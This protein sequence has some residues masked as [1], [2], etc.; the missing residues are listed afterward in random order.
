MQL[1][2]QTGTLN[3]SKRSDVILEAASGVTVP[4]LSV[5]GNS[6]FDKQYNF[7]VDVVEGDGTYP[8][9]K[10]TTSSALAGSDVVTVRVTAVG[11]GATG[12]TW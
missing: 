2:T 6:G 1:L 5:N 9:V 8:R 7:N 4:L 3:D 12:G 10:V 11:G